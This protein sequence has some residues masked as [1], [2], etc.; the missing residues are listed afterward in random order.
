MLKSLCKFLYAISAATFFSLLMMACAIVPQPTGSHHFGE[1]NELGNCAAFFASLDQNLSEAHDLDP[2]DFRV[3]GYPYLRVNRF[4]ASFGGESKTR[5]LSRLGLT[6]CNPLTWN[7]G[8]LKLPIW[9]KPL[10]PQPPHQM[11]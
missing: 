6:R 5:K 2:G 10:S 1:T 11:I 9:C 7:P 8:N 4:L 3:E